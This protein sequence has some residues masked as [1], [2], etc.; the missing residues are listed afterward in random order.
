MDIIKSGG[1][2]ISGLEIESVPAPRSRDGYCVGQWECHDIGIMSKIVIAASRQ[3]EMG[4]LLMEGTSRNFSYDVK[5]SPDPSRI[6][7]V[8]LQH[9]KIRECAVVGKPDETWGEKAP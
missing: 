4:Y 7:E 2:K 8:L 1:Y 6:F 9:E 3:M 5:A